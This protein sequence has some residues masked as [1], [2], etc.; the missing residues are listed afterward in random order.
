MMRMGISL[1][2][3]TRLGDI[4]KY[5]YDGGELVKITHPDNT[6]VSYTYDNKHYLLSALDNES[7]YGVEYGW[8]KLGCRIIVNRI[9][10]FNN[11]GE[12]KEYGSDV[13][14]DGHD[15][16]HTVY[17]S[18]GNDNNFDTSDDQI[19]T[20]TF[21]YS[22]HTVNVCTKDV[23]GNVLGVDTGAY[24]SK[25]AKNSLTA[26]ATSGKQAYSEIVNG[27]IEV[28]GATSID[29]NSW[30]VSG[31]TTNG[32]V[33][34]TNKQAHNGDRSIALSGESTDNSYVRAYAAGRTLSPG[35][36]TFSAY[37]K[38]TDVKKFGK[39][40]GVFLQFHTGSKSFSTGRFFRLSDFRR[41]R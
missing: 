2:L 39:D 32:S 20:Y 3:Q 25:S 36:Y 34:A 23:Q 1:K 15:L 11:S 26:S 12:T 16:Q 6:T 35:T 40:G 9:R 33:S 10:E 28:A 22:G 5:H 19:S 31:S 7:K 29:I 17:T 8:E 14:V 18:A 27:G 21:D 41:Y 13:K 37:V 24:K 4:T 38:T 30:N